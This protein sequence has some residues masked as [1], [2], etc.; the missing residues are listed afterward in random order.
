M[1]TKLSTEKQANFYLELM[2]L[3]NDIPPL[4]REVSFNPEQIKRWGQGESALAIAPPEVDTER[5]FTQFILV[6]KACQKWQVGPQPVTEQLITR[7]R[8]LNKSQRHELISSLLRVDGNKA[9][10][11][12]E[13][14]VSSS[15]LEYIA[16]NTF[17]PLL[18]AYGEKVLGQ[19]QISDWEQSYCPVCGDQPT[20]A[21]LTGEDG[22]RRLHCGRC[23]T[24]WRFKRLGCPYCN[25]VA[26]ETYF[27]TLDNKKE[28]RVYLCDKCKSYL[29]TVDERLTGEVDLFCADLATAELDTLV[30]AEGYRRGDS[31]EQV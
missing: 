18:K 2:D 17:K 7:L 27:I 12:K 11:V 13:L 16:R 23:E 1:E 14:N 15:L 4:E 25:D 9:K 10:W 3:E 31:R 30:Q 20:I 19:V 26:D 24:D 8:E 29:K 28:Y 6:A 22:H 5:I 21:K